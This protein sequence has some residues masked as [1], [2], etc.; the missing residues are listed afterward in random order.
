[1]IGFESACGPIGERGVRAVSGCVTQRRVRS[2]ILSSAIVL[3]G[4]SGAARAQES[5]EAAAGLV[6]T[7]TLAFAE[8]VVASG[9]PTRVR[10][11]RGL[12]VIDSVGHVFEF[13]E[14]P[15]P[16]GSD[17]GPGDRRQAFAEYGGFWGR[18]E[19]AGGR[20]DFAAEAGV[21]PSV[22]G[23]SFSRSYELDGDRLVMTST[24][25]P[26]AQAD[27]RWTWE[28]VPTVENLTP[29]YRQV[30]GFWRHVDERR[31][32]VATGEVEQIRERNPSLIVYTPA[33][34]LGVHFPA[35]D[36]EPFD[37]DVPSRE[38]ADA[39]WRRYIGYYGALGLYPGEVAHNVLGGTQPG[40]GAILRRYA[41]IDGDE[42]V[43]TIPGGT[44][45]P[46]EGPQFV[47]VV[48]MR[49]LS[50]IDEMLPRVQ[51]PR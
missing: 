11:S 17:A 50:G 22:R 33:G 27:K 8:R 42:A 19:I 45:A 6:G 51:T 21:S 47:T 16:D 20:I 3:A 46:G 10:G 31:V 49:R 24:N 1:M 36:R 39:A 48:N 40:A 28:R 38:E 4:L 14:V 23:L 15:E 7:W 2:L 25:E 41:A 43:L 9:E 30:I 34:Y 18:Y 13:F 29:A 12:L 32:N 26:Q 44:R 5:A 37:G 35:L